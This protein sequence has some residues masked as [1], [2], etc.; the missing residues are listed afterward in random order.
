VCLGIPL[1]DTQPIPRRDVGVVRLNHL[2][3][4]PAVAGEAAGVLAEDPFIEIANFGSRSVSGG[5][6]P[7]QPSSPRSLRE[8]LRFAFCDASVVT[9]LHHGLSLVLKGGVRISTDR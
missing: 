1:V 9:L 8:P 3:F 6:I 4:E 5:T 7:G 2:L